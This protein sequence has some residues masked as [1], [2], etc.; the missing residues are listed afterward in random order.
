VELEIR[1][2]ADQWRLAVTDEGSGLP[3]DQLERVFARFVRYAPAGSGRAEEVAGQGLGLAICRG[4]AQLHG[5]TIRAENRGD[6][7]TGLRVVVELPG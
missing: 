4:I 2:A 3:G 5:G 7:R 1:R 6:G